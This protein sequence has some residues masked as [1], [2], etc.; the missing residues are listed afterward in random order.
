MYHVLACGETF[1][2]LCFQER[3]RA[4][5]RLRGRVAECGLVYVEHHW[6]WDD[7]DR[8]QLL[9]VSREQKESAQKFKKFLEQN[10]IEARI[11]TELPRNKKEQTGE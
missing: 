5:D 8:A 6:V 11:I 10:K 1:Q 9:I 2:G 3:D 4:R 7:T